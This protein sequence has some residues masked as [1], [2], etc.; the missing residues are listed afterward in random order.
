MNR[1][2]LSLVA[3]VIPGVGLRA[4]ELT[5]PTFYKNAYEVS[6]RD[7]LI[8][9]DAASTLVGGIP[10]ANANQIAAGNALQT[11]LA[12]VSAQLRSRLN[13]GGIAAGPG[14]TGRAIVSGVELG[15]GDRL[16]VPIKRDLNARLQ[17]VLRTYSGT[18]Q[19]VTL[20]ADNEALV[21]VI[22]GVTNNGVFLNLPGFQTPICFLP[23]DRK[24]RLEPRRI[25]APAPAK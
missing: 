14:G 22:G 21:L 4:E 16:V 13:V 19:R 5:L 2:L 24:L 12:E 9:A 23:Y 25:D 6:R 10:V 7:P 1:L 3:C 17:G 8:A 11:L 15:T 18:A 20:D